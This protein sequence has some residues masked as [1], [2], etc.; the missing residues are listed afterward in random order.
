MLNK[1]LTLL[2]FLTATYATIKDCDTS[3]QFKFTDLALYPESPK[4]GEN[5]YMT[6]IFH[7]PGPEIIDGKAVTSVTWNGIPLTP[8]TKPLCEST[9]CPLT[10]GVNNRSTMS[11][12]PS[13]VTGKVNSKIQW[14]DTQGKSLLCI[15]SSVSVA[16]DNSKSLAPAEMFLGKDKYRDAPAPHHDN[17]IAPKP[18]SPA[19]KPLAPH[20]AERRLRHVGLSKRKV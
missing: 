15:Q 13:G 14:F 8:T 7:N 3:S 9:D 12:W 6:V 1:L 4:V 10:V 18:Q 16:A 20:P 19:P 11:T 2:P 17:P 5:V